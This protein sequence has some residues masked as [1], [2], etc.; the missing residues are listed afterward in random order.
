MESSKFGRRRRRR[1]A[2]AAPSQRRSELKPEDITIHISRSGG[3]FGR[4]LANDYMVE[5]AAVAKQVPG[6]PVKLLWTREDDIAHDPY[7]P[8]GFHYFSGG[9]DGSGKLVAW[10]DHFVTS[11][12]MA[13]RC[14]A[15]ISVPAS[16]R[17][18]SFRISSSTS[19]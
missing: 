15:P 13:A 10:R 8:A 2:G 14:R 12:P 1:R 9:V 18:D 11:D 3:G 4:R 7:R 19:R 17:R 5:A 16:S 6:V